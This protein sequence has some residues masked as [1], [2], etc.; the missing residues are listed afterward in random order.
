MNIMQY[1]TNLLQKE[2]PM[3]RRRNRKY[4]NN[5]S[6]NKPQKPLPPQN[7]TEVKTI[8]TPATKPITTP[9]TKPITT[10]AAKTITTP[11]TV[12]KSIVYPYKPKLTFSP[13][14]WAKMLFMRDKTKNEVGAFAIA[15]PG[16]LLD[17]IDVVIVKQTVG[18]ASVAFDDEGVADFFDA[19]V[20]LDR[21]PTEF[22]RIWVHTHPGAGPQPSMTDYETFNRVF[23]VTDWAAMFILDQSGG[24]SCELRFNVGPKASMDI[25]VGINY[26]RSFPGTDFDA[27]EKEYAANV[28]T[29]KVEYA[30]F[31]QR[32]S[33]Y[34]KYDKRGCN[35]VMHDEWEFADTKVDDFSDLNSSF[36]S[37]TV[38]GHSNFEEDM[39]I[40]SN[41][42]CVAQYCSS[43]TYDLPCNDG[44]YSCPKCGY[45]LIPA[46]DLLASNRA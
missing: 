11:A 44:F 40:C 6:D 41:P 2:Q 12:K 30:T 28:N 22:A 14:A 17:I 43:C 1:L 45:S 19:Q 37:C 9:V 29:R 35:D 3:P 26:T 4:S 5:G 16:N 7:T 27:W 15:T 36:L 25:P 38:C 13:Y 34:P 32:T 8:T 20:L 18:C 31:P 10:P 42:K 24:T 33:K 39:E 23:G 46:M 21:K